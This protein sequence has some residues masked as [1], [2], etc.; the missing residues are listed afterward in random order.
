MQLSNLGRCPIWARSPL[1]LPYT[2]KVLDME[3]TL[4][5]LSQFLQG[6]LTQNYSKTIVLFCLGKCNLKNSIYEDN[7]GYGINVITVLFSPSQLRSFCIFFIA[8]QYKKDGHCRFK[9][10]E[11]SKAP[12][13]VFL[14][15]PMKK[16]SPYT[17]I[18]SQ[19]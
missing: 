18:V 15:M 9:L 4:V 13:P 2:F 19:G 10:S 7:N 16:G 12:S 3:N 17:R 6:K 1:L 11:T 14:H 5:L 8:G